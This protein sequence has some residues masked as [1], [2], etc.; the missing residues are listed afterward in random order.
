MSCRQVNYA[1]RRKAALIV[2]L[3]GCCW[4]CG[5]LGPLHVDHPY[6]R[7]YQP[8]KLSFA[9][10]IITYWKEYKLGLVRLLCE[11]C[12]DSRR[13][14]GVT[15]PHPGAALEAVAEDPGEPF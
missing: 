2:E 14:N 9:H 10:R 11:S 3:G 15:L 7:D 4:A 5:S 13:Y 8:R 12:N 1:N 6:G